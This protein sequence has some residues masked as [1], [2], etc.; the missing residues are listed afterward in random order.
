MIRH[1]P[2]RKHDVEKFFT[3]CVCI[4]CRRK[5]LTESLPSNDS[6]GEHRQQCDLINLLLLFFF[7]IR[8]VD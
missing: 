6:W 5:V 7:K 1:G 4:R 2:H 3:Y 8:K